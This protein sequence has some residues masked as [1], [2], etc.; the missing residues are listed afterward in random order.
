MEI[1]KETLKK[2]EGLDKK[3]MDKA[4][5]RINSLIKPVGSLGKLEEIAVQLSGITGELYPKVDNRAII[6]MAADNGVMEEKVSPAPQEV[7]K[8]MTSYIANGVSGVGAL[9]NQA[10]ADVIVVDIGVASEID[11]IKVVNRKIKYGTENITK[12]PAMTKD[13]AIKAVEVGIEIATKEI[14]KGRNLLGTGE[15]GIGNTT[16]STAIL[17]VMG[18]IDPEEITGVGANLPKDQLIN[19][20]NVIKKAIEINRPNKNDWLDV[21]SK[22]GGLDIAGMAGVMVAGAANRVPVV[23][24][25]YISTAAAIIAVAMEPKIRDFLIPSHASN[26]KGA[27]KASELL[28]F[29]PPLYLNMRLGEGTGAAIMF[30]IIEAAVFMI[31]KMITFGEAGIEAV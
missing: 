10:R 24:D 6:T 1:L 28:G 12:G 11:N 16:T 31:K 22:V 2:I 26:E 27:K 3:S 25:G 14:K 7:T 29:E 21:L 23:V 9:A 30:N 17:S 20:I 19:K 8:I 5:E 18:G 13:E 15:M 4:R